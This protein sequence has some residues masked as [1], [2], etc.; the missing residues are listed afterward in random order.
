MPP[1]DASLIEELFSTG[2]MG[3][4]F[5]LEVAEIETFKKICPGKAIFGYDK[6]IERLIN[7][8]DIFGKGNVY[9]N[10]IIGLESGHKVVERA[11]KLAESGIGIVPHLLHIDIWAKCKEFKITEKEILEIYR[12]LDK[13][14]KKYGIKPWLNL[15]SLRGCLSWE[16]YLNFIK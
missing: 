1:E 11:N 10:I 13:I 12:E 3:V 6:I 5:N 14:N 9:S 15:E 4:K 16:F 2:I 7:A 8:V